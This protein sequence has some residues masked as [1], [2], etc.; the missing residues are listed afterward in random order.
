MSRITFNNKSNVFYTELKNEVEKYFNQKRL[1]KTGNWKLFLKTGILVPSAILIYVF[2]LVFHWPIV[3]VILMSALLGLVLTSI[4][5]NVMH[6][7]C[8]GSYSSRQ[9]TNKVLG[10]SMNALG[11]NAFIWKQK[12]NIIHHTYTNIEGVDDDI[13]Q[14]SLLRQCSTQKWMPV[15][16]FQH[17]YLLVIYSLAI[18]AWV[19]GRDYV[20]YFSKKI[21]TTPLQKMSFKDHF[22][23]WIS[24]LLY[25]VFYMFIPI[26]C[27]GWQTWL[28]GFLT[29]GLVMGVALSVVFQLAHSVEGPE[30][31]VADVEPKKIESE[32]AAHQVK[33]TANFA[34][35]NKVISWLVGGLNFQIEHHLFPRISHVHYPALSKIVKKLCQQYD[36]PYHNFPTMWAAFVSHVKFMK[37][38]GRK[39]SLAIAS[40]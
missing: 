38:M 12:H 31:I 24:K 28:L 15:H 13:A 10:L 16:R 19:L 33:T 22:T 17:I 26:L 25:L 1:K 20:R 5:F 7:A 14:S 9:W 37:N 36:L 4:G 11:G 40:N 3:G 30:F 32:W 2:L 8:H 27:M 21:H 35:N 29:M 18:F 6:D 39:P 23:F 34:T